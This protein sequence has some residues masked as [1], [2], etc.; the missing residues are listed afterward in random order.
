MLGR[1]ASSTV[2]RPVPPEHRGIEADLQSTE[3]DLL[4]H[5][6]MDLVDPEVRPELPAHNRSR[7]LPISR[8]QNR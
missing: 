1:H 4:L 6:E 7:N 8:R 5:G 3:R 2:H